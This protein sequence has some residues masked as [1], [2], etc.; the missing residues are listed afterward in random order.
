MKVS[1][2]KA[3]QGKVDVT[4]VVKSKSEP[5]TMNKYGKDLKVCTAVVSDDSGEVTLTLWNA[6]VDKVNVGD[7]VSV[8]NG[9]VSEFNGQKQL[10]SG[11]FGKLEVVSG[12]KKEEKEK[13]E[14]PVEEVEF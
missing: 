10:T 8:T 1:E 4:V 7:K 9:Y 5:R 13:E 11:K 2:L 6:D 3:G 12:E 14:T